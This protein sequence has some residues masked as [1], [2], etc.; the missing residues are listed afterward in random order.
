[1]GAKAPHLFGRFAAPKALP[2][3]NQDSW[4]AP[5]LA[6]SG[7]FRQPLILHLFGVHPGEDRG[8]RPPHSYATHPL[9][10]G[11]GADSSWAGL[12]LCLLTFTGIAPSHLWPYAT[13]FLADYSLL[14]SPA[15]TRPVPARRISKLW[16]CKVTPA[17]CTCQEGNTTGCISSN[18][19]LDAGVRVRFSTSGIHTGFTKVGGGVKRE[20]SRSGVPDCEPAPSIPDRDSNAPGVNALHHGP[21]QSCLLF[22]SL[23]FSF[24]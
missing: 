12:P 14:L 21:Y 23:I 3:R 5:I 18:D 6:K 13:P 20:V 16:D 7:C 11:Y 8:E 1:M 24:R 22:S 19:G 15:E 2:S 4:P 10:F 9:I 17:Y